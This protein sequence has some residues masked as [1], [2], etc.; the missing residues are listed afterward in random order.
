MI[1]PAAAGDPAQPY[2]RAERLLNLLMAL[3]GTRV[4]L[5]RAEIRRVVRG[6]GDTASPEAFER[7]FE[8][9]KDDL[10][11]MGIPMVTRTDASGSVIGYRIEGDWSLPPLDLDR[12]EL[13][14]LGLAARMWQSAELAPA[15][16][17]ALR[18]VEAQLGMPAQPPVAAPIAGLSADSP[19]LP[20]LIAACTSR[21][22]V[23]FAYRKSSDEQ[24]GTRHVQ[25]WGVVSWRGHW[26]LVGRDVDRDDVRVFRASRISGTVHPDPS[27]AGYDIPDDFDVRAA[28]GR[29][30]DATGTTLT[31]ALAPGTGAS[32][33]QRATHS[34]TRPDS[35]DVVTLPVGD[36]DA[37][38][39]T[40]LPYA[41]TAEVLGP[42]DAVAAWRTDLVRLIDA[43]RSPPSEVVGRGMSPGPGRSAA[44]PAAQFAR[45]LALVPWLAAN[46][47]V[48][49]TAAAAHFGISE[50][51][52]LEDLG[53][54][55]TSGADD[56][57]LFDIQY[58]DDDGVIEVID[59]LGLAKP[60]SLTPDEGFALLVALHALAA[61]PGPHDRSAIDSATGKL[62]AALGHDAPAPGSMAVRVDLPDE[63]V[64]AVDAARTGG[65]ALELT[66]LGAV[67]DEVTERVVDPVGIVVVDGYA[68]LRAWCRR[69]EGL[70]LF[71]ADRI[72]DLRVSA[73]PARP[74][75][76]GAEQ[77][78]PMAVTLA[79]T[80]RRVVVDLPAD[81]RL[82]DRHPWLHRWPRADG[83][84][85]A[86]LPVGDYGWARS[87]VLAAA[88]QVV[89]REPVW[90]VDQILAD[91]LAACRRTPGTNV[92]GDGVL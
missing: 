41:A 11:A 74:I 13:A 2:T 82:L 20:A 56:W 75:P 48:S 72:L 49:V 43:H 31:V 87:V 17:N 90:L 51:Q 62:A 27:A 16:L 77:V 80:G 53:S 66:Y 92:A 79:A 65:R 3:R 22:P 12:T 68:Y 83:G 63:V 84:V 44:A 18:K 60:L 67:R 73:E 52:L 59:A 55:I 1:A 85:R 42:P 54:V 76:P 33:R 26:Y 19:I 45:L 39:A 30:A 34:D 5:D 40:V 81:A 57:T 24:P 88:G 61:V 8:R 32:L 70:R 35:W 36:L 71:R 15:A 91:L 4:G 28:V 37:A 14:V 58:W 86:E 25:P 7:M 23:S 64:T 46:S 6:Y 10:R 78:E 47:G 69:A 50:E 29:F 9:D 89:L 38:M 21:T